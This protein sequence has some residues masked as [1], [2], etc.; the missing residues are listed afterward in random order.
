MQFLTLPPLVVILL[1]VFLWLLLLVLVLWFIMGLRR[2]DDP[3]RTLSTDEEEA[4]REGH[5]D[6]PPAPLSHPRVVR[7]P[8]PQPTPQATPQN[9]PQT[10]P[11]DDAFDGFNRNRDRRDDFDF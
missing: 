10:T 4:Q 8:A 3:E 11:Q 1:L 2:G 7:Q 6:D 9:A 5:R